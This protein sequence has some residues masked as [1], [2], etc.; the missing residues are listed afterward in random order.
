MK[1]VNVATLKQKLSKYL[2]LVENGEEVVVTS[3]QR[4][5]ARLVPEPA[6]GLVF[7]KPTVPAEA[8]WNIKGIKLPAPFS[9]EQFLIEDRRRR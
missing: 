1:T 4:P 3:H 5:V 6:S 2:H 9:A 7:R 8:I